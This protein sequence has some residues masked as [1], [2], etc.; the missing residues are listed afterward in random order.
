[1]AWSTPPKRPDGAQD[2][3]SLPDHQP[4]PGRDARVTTARLEA[5]E[6]SVRNGTYVPNTTLLATRMLAAARWDVGLQA[7][8]ACPGHSGPHGDVA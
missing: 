8:L 4:A 5:L 1:M 2:A 6:A 3:R 7:L